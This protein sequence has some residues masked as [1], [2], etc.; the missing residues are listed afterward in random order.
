MLQPNRKTATHG[1]EADKVELEQA[2]NLRKENRKVV[3]LL[4]D[5]SAEG[6]SINISPSE[7]TG[8]TYLLSSPTRTIQ[9]VRSRNHK[10]TLLFHNFLDLNVY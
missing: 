1:E 5:L 4:N 9:G 3:T 2:G 8:Q 7:S 10:S 6:G